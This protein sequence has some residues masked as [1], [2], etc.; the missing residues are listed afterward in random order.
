M[1]GH[2]K[3]TIIANCYSALLFDLTGTDRL[4][5]CIATG[6]LSKTEGNFSFII[7]IDLHYPVCLSKDIFI[8]FC[9]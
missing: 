9:M 3:T 6:R 4:W 1:P 5:Y 8:Y 7:S 2:L